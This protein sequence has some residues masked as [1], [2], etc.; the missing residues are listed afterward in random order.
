MRGYQ[1]N[2]ETITLTPSSGECVVN[3]EDVRFMRHHSIQASP[4]AQPDG[5]LLHMAWQLPGALGWAYFDE[6]DLTNVRKRLWQLAGT[7]GALKFWLTDL[8]AD[9]SVQV[10]IHSVR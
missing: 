2:I 4:S 3:L 7:V 10:V 9:K 1:D 5:G 8:D 6:M